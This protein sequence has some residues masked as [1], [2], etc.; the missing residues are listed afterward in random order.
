MDGRR[1]ARVAPIFARIDGA[2]RGI[3]V[4]GLVVVGGLVL[5]RCLLGPVLEADTLKLIRG[6]PQLLR[7]I[8]QGDGEAC[9]GVSY[10]AILQHLPA[11]L[12][13]FALGEARAAGDFLVLLSLLSVVGLAAV[14]ALALRRRGPGLAY[15]WLLVVLGSP[16][17]LYASRSFSETLACFIVTALC[18]LLLAGGRPVGV[19]LLAFLAGL[20]KETAPLFLALLT[21]SA[22]LARGPQPSRGAWLKPALVVGAGL[23]V[24]FALNGAFN[25]LRFGGW[26]NAFYAQPELR[27]SEPGRL[28]SFAAAAALSPSGGFLFYWPAFAALLALYVGSAGSSEWRRFGF[29][30]PLATLAAFCAALALWHAPFG[31]IGWGDRLLLPWLPPIAWIVLT[32]RAEALQGAASRRHPALLWLAGALLGIASLPQWLV[33]LDSD[34]IYDVFRPV[35][36]CPRPPDFWSDIAYYYRCMDHYLWPRS[37]TLVRILSV[38]TETP[39]FALTSVAYVAMFAAGVRL[40]CRPARVP[41]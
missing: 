36:G 40:S 33:V 15:A 24:S 37:P 19:A 29:W 12:G 34:L 16:L 38:V 11:A 9:R 6:V 28:L 39:L 5:S 21:G 8:A 31:W 4:L 23:L 20:S 2:A 27:V 10:F 13:L 1:L 30:A 18:A 17:P 41:V 22:L 35:T 14:F 26:S 3:F 25:V 32:T 7:C